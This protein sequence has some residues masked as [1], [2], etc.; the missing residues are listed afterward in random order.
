MKTTS[1]YNG[2]L[3]CKS[4]KE[5][6]EMCY[7]YC[8]GLL[9]P[10]SGRVYLFDETRDFLICRFRFGST[11][12]S[13]RDE[14]ISAEQSKSV[15]ARTAVENAPQII[16]DIHSDNRAE[17][18]ILEKLGIKSIISIPILYL[19]AAQGVISFDFKEINDFNDNDI[20][21]LI[22]FVRMAALIRENSLLN[23]QLNKQDE[24][25][26]NEIEKKTLE[27]DKIN[28]QLLLKGRLSA[29]GQLASGVA[30]EI[31]NPLAVIK[32][33]VST[34]DQE[35]SEKDTHKNDIGVVKSE[36]ER[37]DEI[38]NQFLNLARPKKFEKSKV[39]INDLLLEVYEFMKIKFTKADIKVNLDL[40][41]PIKEIYID[42]N[43]M[44]QVFVNILLNAYE[45]CK[46]RQEAYI[47]IKT[48]LVSRK[49]NVYLKIDISDTGPGI[50]EEII[51]QIFTPFTTSREDGLGLGLS[52]CYRIISDHGGTITAKNRLSGGAKFEILLPLQKQNE[53]P[54]LKDR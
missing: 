11:H 39:N 34:V 40:Y 43:Q 32:M 2:L 50:K 22:T 3:H 53:A 44:K 27:L 5:L 45:I 15:V 6:F 1:Y 52:I 47:N 8:Q 36:L 49:N 13:D 42:K 38:V 54:I 26:K 16:K 9:N 46:D 17:V 20:I 12:Y 41:I 48:F 29:L 33:I 31:K 30:H 19:G 37:I 10:D 7:M 51:S 28:E 25:F 21:A 24:Y 23:E 14:K 4:Q 18:N 35:L